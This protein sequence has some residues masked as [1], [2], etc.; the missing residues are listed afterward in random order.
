MGQ[1][2]TPCSWS[3]CAGGVDAQTSA[4]GYFITPCV[5]ILVSIVCYLSLPHLVSLAL[6]SGLHFRASQIQP[7]PE[8]EALREAR[9]GGGDLGPV[10]ISKGVSYWGD[11]SLSANRAWRDATPA[12]SQ[13]GPMLSSCRSSPATTW[14]RNHR[15]LKVGSWR[16]KLSSSGLVSPG[17]CWGRWRPGGT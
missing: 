11:P 1:A 17:P 16:P 9:G 6:S 5:G 12:L 8:S 7:R 3:F 15:W 13:A 2:T 10:L 14:P 4:L